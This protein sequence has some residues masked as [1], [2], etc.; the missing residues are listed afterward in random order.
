MQSDTTIDFQSLFSQINTTHFSFL[1]FLPDAS[2][3]LSASGSAAVEAVY[4]DAGLL[5]SRLFE[6]DDGLTQFDSYIDGVRS[7]TLLTDTEDTFD[8]SDITN[9]YDETG[10]TR[11]E[12]TFDDGLI[13]VDT[14]Q[15][16][17]RLRA[18][19]V[20]P[21]EVDL[22]DWTTRDVTY[23]AL[24]TP[25][26][27]LTRF[28]D[29]T[30]RVE[31][32]QDG[33]KTQVVQED[34]VLTAQIWSIVAAFFDSIGRLDARD[35][36]YDDGVVRQD[37]FSA[38]VRQKSFLEDAEDTFDWNDIQYLYDPEGVVTSRFQVDDNGDQTL[39]LFDDGQRSERVILDVNGDEDWEVQVTT[40]DTT[41]VLDVAEYAEKGTVLNDYAPFFAVDEL[42]FN[43]LG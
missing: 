39:I 29:G 18:Y 38:G 6:R 27:R 9:T 36:L 3:A 14:F 2:S 22:K 13:R 15:A 26:S 16:G 35:L 24:G 42:L 1:S 12:T 41:G 4:D 32:F 28:D 23:D 20:D 10:R 37:S 43:G 19:Q 25:L 30:E 5:V 34:L 21:E 7:T 17:V 11:K 40:Y 33:V 31:T 8:W